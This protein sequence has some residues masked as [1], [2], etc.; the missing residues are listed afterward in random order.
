MLVQRAVAEFEGPAVHYG[1]M[2]SSDQEIEC[3]VTRDEA[4]TALGA[5]CFEREAAGMMDNFQCL[6]VRGICDYADTHKNRRWQVHAATTAAASAKA[7]PE[8]VPLRD[9]HDM[10]TIVEVIKDGVF[11]IFDFVRQS[12]IILYGATIVRES[13]KKVLQNVSDMRDDQDAAIRGI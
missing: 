9:I 3:G 6:V 4:K 10:A 1:V 12:L 2:A 13:V 8:Y 7:L 11:P 5:M